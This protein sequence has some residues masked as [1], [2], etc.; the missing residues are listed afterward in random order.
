MWELYLRNTEFSICPPPTPSFPLPQECASLL[1]Q[2]ELLLAAEHSLRIKLQRG[3]EL[4]SCDA[5][6]KEG[7]G[8]GTEVARDPLERERKEVNMG[9]GVLVES[10]ELT[11]KDPAHSAMGRALQGLM[12]TQVEEGV[13]MGVWLSPDGVW[14]IT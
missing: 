6:G 9:V 7:S 11:V 3:L 4:M 1:S 8:V 14:L 12:M 10:P 2:A 5:G 13:R